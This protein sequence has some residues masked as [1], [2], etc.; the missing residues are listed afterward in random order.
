MFTFLLQP[1]HVTVTS[2]NH[3]PIFNIEEFTA[4]E[5]A[6]SIDTLKSSK[7]MDVYRLI[8]TFL[9]AHRD[10]LLFPVTHMIN[11]SNNQ[12]TV[13]SVWKIATVTPIYKSGDQTDMANYRPISILPVTSKVMEKWVVKQ[14]INHLNIDNSL[15]HLMQFGFRAHHST[16]S[17]ISVLLE[18]VKNSLDKSTCVGAV[19]MDLKEAFNTVNHQ[20][21]IAKLNS[22]NFSECSKLW[23]KSYLSRRKQHA[24]VD[25]ITSPYLECTVGVPQGSILGPIPFSLFINDSPNACK[26]ADIVMYADDA[27]ILTKAKTSQE[28][29]CILTLVLIPIQ[30]WLTNLPKRL[31]A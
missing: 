1:T 21:F 14:L 31:F 2:I 23:M 7:A 8:Q 28:A 10:S 20:I 30:E 9:K 4:T 17:A 11:Q 25:D 29:S 6:N 22:F 26:N 5:V 16:K 3:A 15:L 12:S 13:P 19:F 24:S 18:K 27:V